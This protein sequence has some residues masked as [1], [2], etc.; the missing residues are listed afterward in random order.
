MEE[1]KAVYGLTY[2]GRPP[3]EVMY[4]K[5]LPYEDVL[6]LKGIE[7][8]VEVY[9]N[10]RQFCYTLPYLE[11]Q[12]E[13]AFVMYEALSKYYEEHGLHMINHSRTTRYE[14]LLDFAKEKDEEHLEQYRQLM[15]LDFYLRENAKNR[16][17]FAGEELIDKDYEKEFYDREAEERN[18]LKGYDSYDKR[19]LRKMTHLERFS[20]D[21]MGDMSEKESVILFD[22]QNR[23][24]LNHQALAM[25]VDLK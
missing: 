6:R 24:P 23:S 16:P 13:N 7:E 19:K 9:Y 25:K 4:T 3:Y 12:F 22:Y 21:V 15:I 14:N 8:M 11:K 1:Q 5:W 20:W 10:S 2:K 18:Y 17:V